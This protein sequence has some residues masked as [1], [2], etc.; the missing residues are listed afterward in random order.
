M[1]KN[2]FLKSKRGDISISVL[3]IGVFFVCTLAMAIFFLT[4]LSKA[5]EFVNGGLIEK[6]KFRMERGDSADDSD[7]FGDFL[8]EGRFAREHWYSLTKDKEIFYVKYY[9]KQ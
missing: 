7:V 2:N 4:S 8:K 9:F 5:G 1:G 6:I 3:V